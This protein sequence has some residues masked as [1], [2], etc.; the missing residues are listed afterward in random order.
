[1]SKCKCERCDGKGCEA[2]SA[3]KVVQDP[4]DEIFVEKHEKDPKQVK[5]GKKNRSSGSVFEKKVRED[6]EKKGWIVSK[7]QNTVEF[8]KKKEVFEISQISSLD[9]RLIHAKNHFLGPGKPVMLGAGFPDFIAFRRQNLGGGVYDFCYDVIGVEAKSNGKLS[10]LEKNK[11]K[12]LLEK[13]IFNRILV[14]SK[15]KEG[16][17]VVVEYVEL[18]MQELV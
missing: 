3:D 11:C 4:L 8:A 14:A 17:K 16:R 13:R 6:L 15:K 2:C 1:M 9:A 10:R 12:F 5:K 7:F 18:K